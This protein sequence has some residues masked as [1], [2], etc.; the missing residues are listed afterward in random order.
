[1]LF[2]PLLFA[3]FQ[4]QNPLLWEVLFECPL[5]ESDATSGLL[6]FLSSLISALPTLGHH[7]LGMGRCPTEL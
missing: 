2:P 1:M 7:R 3:W 5:P 4:L 6:Q